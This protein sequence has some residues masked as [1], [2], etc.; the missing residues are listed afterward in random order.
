MFNLLLLCLSS[1]DVSGGKP[2]LLEGVD[3]PLWGLE[4]DV[5]EGKREFA[6]FK[7]KSNTADQVRVHNKLV[8]VLR[9]V[10]CCAV[11]GA[12][13]ADFLSGMRLG[14]VAD[15]LRESNVSDMNVLCCAVLCCDVSCCIGCQFPVRH[16]LR[17]GCRPAK[18]AEAGGVA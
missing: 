6:E 9:A 12:Q 15:Q 4:V 10:P 11:T 2:V 14:T 3:L 7:A 18:R 5:E 1:Q 8:F 16:G 17:H 13:A